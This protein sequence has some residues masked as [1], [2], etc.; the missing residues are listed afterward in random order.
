TAC[1]N[2]ACGAHS[3]ADPPRREDV[4]PAHDAG[5]FNCLVERL[6][7]SSGYKDLFL[8][9][10]GTGGREGSGFL[11]RGAEA[12]GH[13]TGHINWHLSVPRAGHCEPFL[14]DVAYVG[15]GVDECDKC[16]GGEV[17]VDIGMVLLSCPDGNTKGL[18]GAIPSQCRYV[19]HQNF[20]HKSRRDFYA[21]SEDD[22][23]GEGEGDDEW[24]FMNLAELRKTGVSHV[25]IVANI[26][27]CAHGR[28]TSPIGWQDLEGA[29]MR[30]TGSS[31]VSKSFENAETIG[32]VDLDG[33]QGPAQNGAGLV[34]FY[35]AKDETLAAPSA[36]TR[37]DSAG[38]TGKHWKM[39]V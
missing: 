7:T 39:A 20:N 12:K 5:E 29:F 15:I 1:D 9:K 35:L 37:T 2:R 6:Y 14:Q 16:R 26:Y 33:M 38:G 17:D 10:P 32:Y 8:N 34:M 19:D 24:A 36:I 23:S 27:G 13:V 25:L 31:G 18:G 3:R 22:R 30:V 4:P 21:I 28:P 11:F